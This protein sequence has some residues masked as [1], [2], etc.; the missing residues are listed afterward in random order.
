MHIFTG[1]ESPVL[2]QLK[3]EETELGSGVSDGLGHVTERDLVV[4]ISIFKLLRVRGKLARIIAHP[5]I[6]ETSHR[7]FIC[8]F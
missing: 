7:S 5:R 6:K 8:S 4:R 1:W 2:D 3:K